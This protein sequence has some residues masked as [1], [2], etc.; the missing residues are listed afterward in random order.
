MT[1]QWQVQEAKQRFSELIRAVHT[2][3]P[4][5]VTRHGDRVAVVLDIAEYRRLRGE[6]TD[7]KDFLA[8]APDLTILRIDRSSVPARVV[9]FGGDE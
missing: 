7:F 4:Q 1:G 6:E 9:E 8:S 2:D 5:F 3:G